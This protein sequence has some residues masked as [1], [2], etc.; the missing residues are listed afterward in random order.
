MLDVRRLRLLRELAHRGTIAAVAEALSY[1]PSAV[2]QQLSTLETEAGVPLLERAGRRVRLTAHAEVLV[3]HAEIVLA[4]LERAEADLATS[5]STTGGTLRVAAFQTAALT[6][7]SDALTRLAREHP[8]LRVEVTESEPE[9]SIP[10]LAA[11]DHDLV[12]ADEYPGRPLVR[13]REIELHEISRDPMR[14][15]IA[16]EWPQ[17]SLRRLASRP[18][19]MEPPGSASREWATALCRHVGFEPDIRFASSD[20]LL[21]LRLAEAGH[22]AAVLPDLAGAADR[23]GVVTR[24]LPGDPS[25]RLLYVVRR[26]GSRHPAIRAFAAALR[27]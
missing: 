18:W 22:A 24:R 3:G 21:H 20:L 8:A 1:S 10:A 6:L 7:V 4:E 12:I 27:P 11:R 16:Q 13:R 23:A 2:S 9:Q 15:V 14:L 17:R 25:R 19:V 26:G 5:A